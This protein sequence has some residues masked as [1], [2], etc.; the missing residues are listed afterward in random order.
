MKRSLVGCALLVV[1]ALISMFVWV[2]IANRDY[3]APPIGTWRRS[4]PAILGPPID[5]LMRFSAD[6]TGERRVY[7]VSIP[8]KWTK[9][10]AFELLVTMSANPGVGRSEEQYD[11]HYRLSDD[12]NHVEL[13]G[14]PDGG[15]FTRTAGQ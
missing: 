5:I 9:L 7:S 1:L 2:V 6:G 15:L 4:E 12:G 14:V 10:H 8:F 11:M 3:G 13:N